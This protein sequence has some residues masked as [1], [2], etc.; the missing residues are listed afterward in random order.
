[1]GYLFSIGDSAEDAERRDEP[2]MPTVLDVLR[3]HDRPNLPRLLSISGIIVAL[4]VAGSLA[5]EDAARQNADGTSAEPGRIAESTR[6]HPDEDPSVVTAPMPEM[7]PSGEPDAEIALDIEP[8]IIKVAAV[9]ESRVQVLERR[10][11]LLEKQIVVLQTQAR[12]DQD[13]KSDL[14]DKVAELEVQVIASRK[15]APKQVVSRLP[16]A[17]LPPSGPVR[18]EAAGERMITG[19]VN[20]ARPVGIES[21]HARDIAS[22]VSPDARAAKPFAI[23]RTRFALSLDMHESLE[24]L[25]TAWARHKATHR[26]LLTNL[27]P[28]ALTQGTQDGQLVYRLL[29]GPFDNAASAARHCAKLK[30]RKVQC[31]Q[32][33]FG[34]EILEAPP[35][36]GTL[37]KVE[38]VPPAGPAPLAPKMETLV[39]NPP[40]PRKKPGS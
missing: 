13:I 35:S 5:L 4:I 7:A 9:D 37:V 16:K 22:L 17:S 11:G 21:K 39:A 26:D 30:A 2:A 19:S 23:S 40:L 14:S 28:R 8:V 20:P 33:L 18:I 6:P 15:P 24:K 1:M 12:T 31:S 36:P 27:E 38:M 25:T 29:A 3:L 34:G 10:L 32:T